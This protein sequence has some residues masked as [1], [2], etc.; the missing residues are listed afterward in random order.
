MNKEFKRTFFVCLLAVLLVISNLIGLKYTNFLDITIG[1]DFITF[2]FTF[3]CTLLIINM[4]GKRSAYRSVLAVCIIQLLITIS[5]VI[6]TSLGSQ[7]LMPDGATYVNQ[8]FKVNELKIIASVL[9]FSASHCLLIYVYDNFTRYNK[10]LYGLLIGLL[11]ALVLNS[12]IYLGISLHMYEL[13]YI[14]NM[15]L[16]NIIVDIVMIIIIVILF[17]I[18]KENPE[19]VVTFKQEENVKSSDLGTEEIMESKKIT[20]SKKKNTG[21][22]NTKKTNNNYRKNTTNNKT[23]K[24]KQV[25]SRKDNK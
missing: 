8:V 4:G 22:K 16:S 25:K 7:S 23:N 6:A 14:V 13:M 9:A 5:Y 24:T 12:I 21:N 3:L 1:V 18:L 17:Y 11:G 19:K 10:E 2:P 15:I 20:T